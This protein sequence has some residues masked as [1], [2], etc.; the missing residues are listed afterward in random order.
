MNYNIKGFEKI[1]FLVKFLKDEYVE[2]LL[3]GNLHMNNFQFFIDLE[4]KSNVKGQGDKLEAGFVSRGTK[5]K[6]IDPKTKKVIGTARKAELIERYTDVPKVPLFCFTW[7]NHRDMK[8]TGETE[9]SFIV[10]INLS[11]EEKELFVKDFGDTAVVLPGDFMEILI[12]SAKEQNKRAQIKS[13]IYCD[14]DIY[15][16]ERKKLFDEAS[17]DMFYWKDEFFKYQ[18]EVRFILPE[19]RSNEAV[20]FKFESIEKRAIVMKTT[21][22]LE[23]AEFELPKESLI[24]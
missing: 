20:N 10:K 4:R 6:L 8:I 18:R 12:N 11:E 24:D 3:S 17:L 16:S 2:S 9:K 13:V 15:D 21:E 14:Y 7:F 1:N 23:T 19:T 5:I 22:L